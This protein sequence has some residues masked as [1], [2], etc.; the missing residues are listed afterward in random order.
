M[1][2]GKVYILYF[3]ACFLLNGT[4]LADERGPIPS[5][6]NSDEMPGNESASSANE[7]IIIHQEDLR[8]LLEAPPKPKP[9][10]AQ[11]DPAEEEEPAD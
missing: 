3:I 4:S 1:L 11:F 5:T 2:R 10:S 8:A 6:E 9:A 7:K